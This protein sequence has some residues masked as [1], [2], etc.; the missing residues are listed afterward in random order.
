LLERLV[1]DGETLELVGELRRVV[2]EPRRE[3]VE[4]ETV[5]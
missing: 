2:G 4:T 5:P 3:R 1:S